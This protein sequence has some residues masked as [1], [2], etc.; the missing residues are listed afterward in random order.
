MP[1]TEHE[2]PLLLFRNQP[3][4]AADLVGRAL[5][6]SL[7]RYHDGQVIS[8]DLTDIQPAEYRA[9]MVIQLS[10]GAT[11]VYAIIVEVQLSVDHR[12]RFTWP[13]YV[14]HLRARL[15]CPVA[16]LVVTADK[17][18]ARWAAKTVYLG[19]MHHFAPY[20]L[21]LSAVPVVTDT[22]QSP[23]LAV[24][25]VMAHGKDK[26]TK[27]ASQIALAAL[28][29]IAGLDA[30]RAE[31]YFDLIMHYSSEAA[32]AAL[33]TMD[34]RKYEF[35][36][37]FARHY[38]ALGRTEGVAKGEALGRAAI[39]LRQLTLRFGALGSE[40]EARIQRA[41]IAELETISERLL[42]ARTLADALPEESP[43]SAP[44]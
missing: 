43:L 32:R 35:K 4:L 29:A 23:E 12:K 41:S 40:I 28:R 24:L 17:A 2:F 21:H 39:V 42:T 15:E 9:D 5:G 16:L 13:A 3:T 10:R 14:A 19:G 44:T 20:V 38:I 31:I 37:D 34:A 36:S 1:S 11:T 26:N 8:A 27:L 25:S 6:V 33:N 7:P 18:V 30:E 22:C